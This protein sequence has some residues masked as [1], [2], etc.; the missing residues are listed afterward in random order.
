MLKKALEIYPNKD[1]DEVMLTADDDNVGSVQTI[2]NC[3]GIK[4]ESSVREGNI[5]YG[6]FWITL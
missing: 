3:G 5:S 2:L 4:K 1:F 6:R